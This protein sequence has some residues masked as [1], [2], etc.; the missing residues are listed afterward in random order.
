MEKKP[1][2]QSTSEDILY[3]EALISSLNDG[4]ISLDKD[5]NIVE[6]NRG[7]EIIFGYTK[8]EA[9]GKNVDKLVGQEKFSEA[10]EI[11][12]G[13]FKEGRRFNIPDT[14]RYRKDGSPV[15]VSIS[16]SPII[17]LGK[18]IGAVA[19]YKDISEWKEKERQIQALKEFNENIVNSLA[20][21]ILIEDGKGIITFINPTLE[22]SSR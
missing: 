10:K 15:E 6:W 12:N 18:I 11:T 20:E 14:V 22:K 9:L 8:E 13:T 3:S 4:I 1:A 17:R 5:N 19:I 7:A 2:Y 16:S 21:G